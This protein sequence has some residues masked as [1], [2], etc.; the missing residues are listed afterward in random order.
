MNRLR[1]KV[2]PRAARRAEAQWKPNP[3]EWAVMITL[4]VSSV[5]VALDAT[6]LVSVIPVRL[7]LRPL[8]PCSDS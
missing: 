3:R 4:A 8:G 2:L 6:I 1:E 7:L 5:A